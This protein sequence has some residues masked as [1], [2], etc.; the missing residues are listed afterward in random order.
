MKKILIAVVLFLLIFPLMSAVNINMESE[1]N[2]GETII[3]SVSGNFLS[4]ISR[5]NVYF[6]RGHTRV[7]FDYDITK[8]GNLYY[9]YVQ[10]EGKS[11]D[12]YSVVI[13]GA[14]YIEN[15]KVYSEDIPKDFK[16]DEET[17]DFA[18]NPGFII[19]DGDFYIQLRNLKNS[20]LFVDVSELSNPVQLNSFQTKKV[21][22]V[23]KVTET[24]IKTINI[25]SNNNDYDFLAYVIKSKSKDV[26][27]PEENESSENPEEEPE[28]SE[29]I[30]TLNCI[31]DEICENGYCI[32]SS[33]EESEENETQKN[34]I[35]NFQCE[36]NET[37]KSGFCVPKESEN[38]SEEKG[39]ECLVNW[40]CIG[41]EICENGYC[42][43]SSPEESEEN[44]TEEY[45]CLRNWNCPGDQI[46]LKGEC[47][48]YLK[49][50]ECNNKYDCRKN[51]TCLDYV[52]VPKETI[53][54]EEYQEETIDEAEDYDII[55]E[56]DGELVVVKNGEVTKEP[57]S[58]KTC[59]ELTGNICSSSQICNG[60]SVYAKDNV[61]CIGNCQKEAPKKNTKLL[62]WAIIGVLIILFLIFLL[63]Y[64]KSKH[65][66]I[67][68]DKIAK[69]R[70]R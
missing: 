20:P 31:G 19:T 36:D 51:E 57:A 9:F 56:E 28:G 54:E 64:G 21:D 14:Q 8:M 6:Y 39:S 1:Y 4:S 70:K 55:L 65:R 40:N 5:N 38:E 26:E 41:D 68:F 48:D 22:I 50:G 34:C 69:G 13:K 61:C 66:K 18:V 30:T 63:K 43:S 16:I 42:I 33:P 49:E 52:C 2:S 15:N 7:S 67:D 47:V 10:T 37:C 45:E 62:G 29:C 53:I 46:C 35:F 44:E 24:S 27:N 23:L 11:P 3:A 32:S 60:T 12:D 58:L 17:A 59:S 25:H